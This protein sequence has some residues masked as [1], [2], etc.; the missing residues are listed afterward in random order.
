MQRAN[1]RFVE[2][3][4]LVLK[5]PVYAYAISA[6][7][8]GIALVLRLAAQSFLPIGYPFVSFFPAV[9]LST[10]LFGLRPGIFTGI[11]CGFLSWYFFIPS[12]PGGSFGGGVILA[13]IFYTA[14]IGIDIALIHWM[15]RANFNLAVER[16]RSR[17]LA[18]NRELL[19]HELQHRVS[20]NLQVVAAMLSLQRRHIDDE[21][22][23]RAMDDA[24][25]RL[26]LIGRISRALYDPAEEGQDLHAFL[27]RLT[28]DVL[29][30]SG[31][32]DIQVTVSAPPGLTLDSHVAV[33]LALIVA[34]AVSNAIEHGLPHRGGTIEVSLED[35]SGALSLRIAD[36]GDGLA[37]DFRIEKGNSLGLRI[38]SALASQLSAQ[39][40]LHPRPEGGAIVRLDLPAQ[41]R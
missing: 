6:A 32:R 19:F 30:A 26:A 13:L 3:L 31:R 34:E 27:T 29:E 38:A 12:G 14:V 9:I 37:P 36:D 35:S 33:P 10:F 5:R 39:F 1:E 24:A 20:N 4:P 21:V 23:A 2:R 15:Q 8:C 28:A 16:E 7:F 22:A 18:E 25:S 17:A 40:G 41:A 11:L